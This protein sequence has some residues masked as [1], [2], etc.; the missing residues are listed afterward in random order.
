MNTVN[1]PCPTATDSK[2]N[3]VRHIGQSQATCRLSMYSR[4]MPIWK[5]E[6]SR[7]C[8]RTKLLLCFL[9]HCDSC[10]QAFRCR[11][12]DLCSTH[13]FKD[14]KFHCPSLHPSAHMCV[15]VSVS[16]FCTKQ[17]PIK[18]KL[19]LKKKQWLKDRRWSRHVAINTTTFLF[20][21]SGL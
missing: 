10:I 13:R 18:F 20:Q 11:F 4:S 8:R 7:C 19:K 5:C 2:E 16:V 14:F 3:P 21:T 12:A 9:M 1:C 6:W 15:C 17:S